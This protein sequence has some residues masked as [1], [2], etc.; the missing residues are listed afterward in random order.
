MFTFSENTNIMIT[1]IKYTLLVFCILCTSVSVLSQDNNSVR[2]EKTGIRD[3]TMGIIKAATVGIEFRIKAGIAIGGT[4]P[5]PIPLEIQQVNSFNPLLNTSLEAE[6]VKSFENSPWGLS[7]GLRLETKGMKTDASVKNYTMTMVSE[8][9]GQVS[10]MWTG[11]V[12]TQVN[13][14]Y[15]TIPVLAL[16]RPGPRWELKLGAYGAYVIDRNFSGFAHDG[17]LRQGDPTGEKVVFEGD[18]RPM[19]DFSDDLSRWDYGSQLAADWRAF[20]HFL[21]GVDLTWGLTSIFKKDF[22]TITFDMYPIFGRLNFA[23]AF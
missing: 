10:G 18:A 16:W 7:F 8:D 11:S 9:G 1:K 3:Y 13:N 19:Y 5:L 12:E 23:Y 2:Y 22:Q 17:Y 4:S 20:P 21:I 15:L 14:S 6:F